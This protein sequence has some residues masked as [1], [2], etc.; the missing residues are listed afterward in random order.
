MPAYIQQIYSLSIIFPIF[1]A[2]NGCRSDRAL[3]SMS[4]LSRWIKKKQFLAGP[5]CI[6][7]GVPVPEI[8]LA[9]AGFTNDINVICPFT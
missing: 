2:L 1:A 4:N 7:G 5:S 8:I 3:Y 9:D 6:I